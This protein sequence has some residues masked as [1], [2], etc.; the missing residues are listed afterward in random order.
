MYIVSRV[1]MS[2]FLIVSPVVDYTGSYRSVARLSRRFLWAWGGCLLHRT[3]RSSTRSFRAC[4]FRR[5]V[6]LFCGTL[7]SA[8]SSFHN[9]FSRL[10]FGWSR[11]FLRGTTTLL[12]ARAHDFFHVWHSD[13]TLFSKIYYGSVR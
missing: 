6:L 2:V 13:Q 3:F 12:W 1:T 5:G 4:R 7:G 10:F 8:S 9:G 11:F